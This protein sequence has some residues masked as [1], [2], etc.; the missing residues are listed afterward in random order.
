M[1]NHKLKKLGHDLMNQ[2]IYSDIEADVVFKKFDSEEMGI[3]FSHYCDYYEN[4]RKSL[5]IFNFYTEDEALEVFSHMKDVM[6]GLRLVT[7][8]RS[9]HVH[10]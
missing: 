4:G 3:C 10:Y 2:L 6:A 5:F 7:D 1:Q 9:N 8:E